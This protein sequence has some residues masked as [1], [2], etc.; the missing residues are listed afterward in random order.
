MADIKIFNPDGLAKPAGTYQHVAQA[1]T[2]N[3]DR[4]WDMW[5]KQVGAG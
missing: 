3:V 1:K 2:Q 5:R 4:P